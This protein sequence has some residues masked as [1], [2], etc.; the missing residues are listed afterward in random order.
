MLARLHDEKEP[1]WVSIASLKTDITLLTTKGFNIVRETLLVLTP[2]NQATVELSEER[3]V[4]GSKVIP[5]MKMLYYALERNVSDLQTPAAIHVY[6]HVK[7]R[8]TD[9]A[10]DLESLSVLTLSTPLEPRFNYLGFVVLQSAMKP[11]MD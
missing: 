1:V 11:S 3:R 7:R 4:S 2:F 10:S 8:V 9:T 6:E 5:M